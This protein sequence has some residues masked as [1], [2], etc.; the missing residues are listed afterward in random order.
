MIVIVTAKIKIMPTD[1]QIYAL[2]ETIHAY[3][4]GCNLVS[5]V[6]F[7]TRELKQPILHQKTYR[8]LRSEIGLRSQ[9]AQSVIKTV[10]AKYKTNVNNGHDWVR[11]QFKKPEYDLVW[12]RD[13]S[14]AA[15]QFS[16]NTLQGRI[17]VPFVA[18]EMDKYFDGS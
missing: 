16:V 5:D 11:V 9:M 8:T 17:K 18:Q 12:N 14:L 10:M 2:Q 4:Q 7:D 1:R 15:N 3:R 6:V 13:Y